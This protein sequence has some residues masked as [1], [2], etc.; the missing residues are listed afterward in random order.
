MAAQSKVVES[1]KRDRAVTRAQRLSC[2]TRKRKSSGDR[3]KDA[4]RSGEKSDATAIGDKGNCS[5][6]CFYDDSISIRGG[7]KNRPKGKDK[8]VRTKQRVHE[9]VTAAGLE[10]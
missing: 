5:L 9:R 4:R 2:G 7:E 8:A 3:L 6:N 1:R 10:R